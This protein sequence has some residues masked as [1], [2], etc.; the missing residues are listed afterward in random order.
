MASFTLRPCKLRDGWFVPRKEE[1]TVTVGWKELCARLMPRPSKQAMLALGKLQ[2]STYVGLRKL[3]DGRPSSFVWRNAD[4]SGDARGL[5][6]SNP[7]LG[8]QLV[9]LYL[10]ES[11]RWDGGVVEPEGK[12]DLLPVSP[13]TIG[14]LQSPSAT[15]R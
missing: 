1:P 9:A 5:V 6:Q 15:R 14:V 4:L 7:Q 12:P 11:V 3:P 8:E 2:A 13:P 10:V